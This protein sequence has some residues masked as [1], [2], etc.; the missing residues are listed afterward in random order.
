MERVRVTT[1]I[2]GMFSVTSVLLV[3]QFLAMINF[4]PAA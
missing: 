2:I 4:A 3:A 1:G